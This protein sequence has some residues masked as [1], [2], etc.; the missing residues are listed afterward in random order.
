MKVKFDKYWDQPN[1]ILLVAS[2]LDPRYKL[3]LLKYCCTEAYGEDVADEKVADVRMWFREYYEYYECMVQSSADRS[4]INS[5]PEVGGSVNMLQT[6]TGKRKLDLGFA[7][8]KKR[9]RPN[10][11]RRSEVDVYLED[12]L[13]TLRE[14]ESFDVLR[15]WKK[16]CRAIT[17]TSQDGSGLSGYSTIICGF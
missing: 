1:K 2:L 8:F 12:P 11:S 15:W 14:A 10:R 5:S 17:C 4:N 13:A 6:L 9:H 3:A 16:K 7:L